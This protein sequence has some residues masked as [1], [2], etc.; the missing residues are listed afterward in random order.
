MKWAWPYE[1]AA[2]CTNGPAEGARHL[3]AWLLEEYPLGW[4]GGI[5]NCR[6]VRGGSTTS[7]HGEG[8]AVDFMLPVVNGLGHPTGHEIVRRLGTAGDRLGVQFVIFDRQQW[9]AKNPG[10]GHYGG[11]HP[12]R[13]HLHIELTRAAARNLTLATLRSVLGG[14]EEDEVKQE[15]IDAIADATY[16]RIKR[17]GLTAATKDDIAK[18][19]WTHKLFDKEPAGNWIHNIDAH[20]RQALQALK[21]AVG[22]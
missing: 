13:D 2:R 9:S 22:K 12:H 16:D 6:T 11:V 7:T 19:V 21:D 17:F 10:G 18:R 3:L 4:S 14:T 20:T 15:D 1:R 8:R 5:F